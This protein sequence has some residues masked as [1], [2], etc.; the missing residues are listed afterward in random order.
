METLGSRISYLR[1][2]KG[3]SQEELAKY[4]KLAKS[5]L[6]MYETNKREPSFET[7]S[8]IA[9]FFGV[10]IDWLLTGKEISK[11][12]FEENLHP[13]KRELIEVIKS[14]DD[15]ET[16]KSLTNIAKKIKK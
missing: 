2:K 14:I 10:S 11:N 9:N 8:L 4:L 16:V 1:S 7:I 6:G 15:I 5:T 3:M 13:V 12:E